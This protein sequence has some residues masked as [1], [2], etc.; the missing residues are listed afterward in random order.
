[1]KTI[2][3]LIFIA[4]WGP[5]LGFA[6]TGC[7][8]KELYDAK[9]TKYQRMYCAEAWPLDIKMPK[10]DCETLRGADRSELEY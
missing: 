5:L 10:P 3:S 9:V 8:S 2:L 4:L 1:M 7:D 6:L